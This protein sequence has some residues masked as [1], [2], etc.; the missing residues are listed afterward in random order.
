MMRVAFRT[1]AALTI[2]TGHVMRCLTLARALREAGAECRFISRDLPG[3]LGARI[4]GAEFGLTLL[5]RPDA[6]APLPPGP[7]DHAAWAGVGWQEDAAQTRAALEAA[8]ADWLV[9]DHYAFDARWQAA[10]CPDGTRI[11]VIDDLAD[12]PHTCDLLVDQNLGRQAS[13]YDTLVPETTRCLTGPRHALL[14]P[15]FAQMR[16]QTLHTRPGRGLRRVMVSMGGVD[17][18]NAT[19]RILDALAGADLP[20]GLELSVVMGSGA[21]ALD[22]VRAQAAAM[23][24]P[25][26]VVVDV[27]DMAA[28]MAA[29]DLAIG[30]AGST[31]WER[32]ALGLP[33][34]IVQIADNQAD[35]ARALSSAG[36]AL[37]PGPPQATDFPETLRT[38]FATACGHLDEMARRAAAICDGDGIGRIVATLLQPEIAFRDAM[39]ADARRVWEWR[40]SADLSVVSLDGRETPYGA[41]Y[42][43]FAAALGNPDRIIRVMM[44]GRLPCGYLRLDDLGDAAARVSICLSD[45]TRGLGLARHLLAEAERIARA[46]ALSLLVAE[47]HPD[48][49]SSLH[50]FL[51][52]GYTQGENAGA[53]QTYQFDLR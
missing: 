30:A 22:A 10:A 3:H 13:D 49:L 36:A 8:P 25:T 16:A 47:V 40:H 7:P 39:E 45:E 52:A 28:R 4:T 43:W 24:V 9:M 17:A 19:G 29:S 50:C 38:A 31:T 48:N 21:P 6:A 53:F 41:H 42:D 18:P 23:P 20:A 51:R 2:G 1:D 11:M 37:D 32:C 35:I 12:R 14:R 26:E 33:T 34:I 46:R 15:E 44:R 5:P 27:A